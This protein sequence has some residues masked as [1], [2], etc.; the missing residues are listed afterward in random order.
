M[1][2]LICAV[3][4][5]VLLGTTQAAELTRE[6]AVRELSQT[7]AQARRDAA[8]RLGEVGTMA[9]VKALVSALRDVDADTRERAEQALWRIWSRSGDAKVDALYQTGIEQMNAGDVRQAIDTFSRIIELKPDYAEGWNKRATLYFVAGD[10]HK[11]LADCDE[12][13]KRN[14]Y[15]FGAL[16]G[17]A[18][19][20]VR[21]EYYERALEYARR[22][23]EIN[24]NLDGMRQAIPIIEHMLD[25]RRKRT[26]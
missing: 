4:S 15:H 10:L 12:V 22:A 18:Q 25:E 13:M 7:E 11:S 23:L 2:A 6:Q 20:Y 26:V 9:D 14:P 24:P 3:L 1:R 8:A 5:I 17:Y 19:I 21:L 16:A